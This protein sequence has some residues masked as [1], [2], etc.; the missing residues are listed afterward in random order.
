MSAFKPDM[1]NS[2]EAGGKVAPELIAHEAGKDVER[3]DF[4]PGEEPHIDQ[5]FA[6]HGVTVVRERIAVYQFTLDPMF[7]D[8]PTCI[9]ELLDIHELER[10]NLQAG[11]FDAFPHGA[12]EEGFLAFHASTGRH[13]K[14]I[15]AGDA[16]LHE[17]NAILVD[18]KGAGT[19]AMR[20][21]HGARDGEV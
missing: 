7:A 1:A 4:L 3:G 15:M 19:D 8:A 2:R 18:H 21:G 11:L 13:P 16:M 5:A 20:L 9:E 17:E 10:L 6:G 12:V 14:V